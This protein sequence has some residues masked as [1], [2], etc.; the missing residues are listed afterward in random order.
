MKL[1]CYF[2][3]K[4]I[5]RL[6]PMIHQNYLTYILD[7]TNLNVDNIQKNRDEVSDLIIPLF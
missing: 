7:H 3:I 1:F 4:N 2:I 6:N 5:P